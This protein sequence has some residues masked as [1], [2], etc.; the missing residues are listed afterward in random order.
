M[1]GVMTLAEKFIFIVDHTPRALLAM[2]L[3]VAGGA[4]AM[5]VLER[6]IGWLMASA[7]WF[8]RLI[9]SVLRRK[10][11]VPAL[12]LFIFCFNGTAM[13][14]YM[15]TGLIP[16]APFVVAF[17]T[18]L[19]VALGAVLARARMPAP[20][21]TAPRPSSAV[22]VCA[23]LTFLLELPSFWYTIAMGSALHPSVLGLIQGQPV[24][25][26]LVPM[27]AYAT[28]ILPVLAVSAAV[29]AYAVRSTLH[30]PEA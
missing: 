27:E 19:N 10:P 30:F 2:V 9:T 5:P 7:D 3:F 11:S 25:P 1:R 18:G 14:V 4:C 16:G 26:L 15:M 20:P 21:S 13:F 23:T 22:R 17:L 24:A 29:E 12:A 8:A 6:R 28:V